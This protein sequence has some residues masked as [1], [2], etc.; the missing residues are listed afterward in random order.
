MNNTISKAKGYMSERKANILSSLRSAVTSCGYDFGEVLTN[1]TRARYYADAR[2]IIWK[3]YQEET[4]YTPAQIGRDFDWN[5]STVF[6]AINR[7]DSL[8]KYD[9]EFSE[10]Y[11]AVRTAFDK[12]ME[13]NNKNN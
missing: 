4:D 9:I 12:V 3:I 7:A 5:R 2:S 8:L 6:S 1:K 11:D 10:L 13:I